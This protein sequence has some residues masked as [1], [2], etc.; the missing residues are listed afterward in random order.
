MGMGGAI[1]PGK[2]TGPFVEK[3]RHKTR[4]SID[5]PQKVYMLCL[6]KE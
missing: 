1:L 4:G 6:H 2:Q 5:N 3:Q